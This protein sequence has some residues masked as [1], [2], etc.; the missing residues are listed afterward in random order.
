MSYKLKSAF[1]VLLWIAQ[2][3]P[4]ATHADVYRWVDEEGAMHFSD[5]PNS[6]PSAEKVEIKTG[7]VIKDVDQQ[8]RLKKQ[9][10]LLSVIEEERKIKQK[11][12][13][14]K[15]KKKEARKKSCKEARKT[16]NEYLASGQLYDI[17]KEGNKIYLSDQEREQ[18]IKK[19]KEAVKYWCK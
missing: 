1:I 11:K 16:L 5:K 8:R 19:A 4:L 2:F 13:A 17:D 7:V 15:K 6:H 12:Q 10:H 9:K 14:E 3:A 18:E